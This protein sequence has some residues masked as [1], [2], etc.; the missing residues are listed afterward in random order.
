MG[1]P[2]GRNQ[3]RTSISEVP[4]LMVGA[5]LSLARGAWSTVER[6]DQAINAYVPPSRVVEGAR[7][8]AGGCE[9]NC[10]I[11]LLSPKNCGW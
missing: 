6:L 3:M 4:L 8:N 10:D 5:V 2:D 11:W 7:E 9:R 1:L